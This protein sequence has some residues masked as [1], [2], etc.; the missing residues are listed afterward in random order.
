MDPG[1]NSRGTIPA[2][3][4]RQLAG[5]P[6][7]APCHARNRYLGTWFFLSPVT[8]RSV[9]TIHR[10]YIHCSFLPWKCSFRFLERGW[11]SLS[12]SIWLLFALLKTCTT[13][14]QTKYTAAYHEKHDVCCL[15]EMLES[16]RHRGNIANEEDLLVQHKSKVLED[17]ASAVRCHRKVVFSNIL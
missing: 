10:R 14:T 13:T 16:L 9:K 4:L 12:F 17:N 2:V 8:F 1:I 6:P 3:V 7:L 5:P 11:L 15:K